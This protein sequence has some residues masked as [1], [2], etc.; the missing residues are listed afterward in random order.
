MLCPSCGNEVPARPTCL[1]CGAS[2]FGE[3]VLPASALGPVRVPLTAGQKARLFAGC[4]PAVVTFA[5]MVA[6]YFALVS[7]AILPRPVALFYVFIVVVLLFTGYQA[8]QNLRDL[9]SG[10]AL[11]Q[12]D[13]LNRSHRSRRGK[14][15]GT[16]W[17]TFERLGRMQMTPNAYSQG[18]PGQRYRVV[19]SPISKIVWTLEPPD[20]RI[21]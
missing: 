2:L 19:Y 9:L 18:S 12:E 16:R 20:A 6:G 10:S 21:R 8:A 7:R 5:L 14:G 3:A 15:R 13:L 1:R 17:G 4:L 11:A